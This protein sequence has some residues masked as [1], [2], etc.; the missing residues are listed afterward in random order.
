MREPELLLL[1]EPFG[2][3]DA[4][5]RTR[6]HAL[7]RQVCARHRPCVLLVTHDIDEALALADR[8]LVLTDGRISHD[9]RPARH[10]SDE[11]AASHT[12]LRTE[13][14]TALGVGPDPAE[15]ASA[16]REPG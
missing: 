12:A 2:A 14:L 15:E 6:M 8:V 7:L 9:L 10:T 11:R 1:D 3:L 13:L 5:T 16:A 4:L